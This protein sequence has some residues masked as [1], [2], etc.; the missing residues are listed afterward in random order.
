MV[1]TK[2]RGGEDGHLMITGVKADAMT[3]QDNI[4]LS[5]YGDF[6]PAKQLVNFRVRYLR[7]DYGG[8]TLEDVM[9]SEYHP[10][11]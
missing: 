1:V 8:T 7:T 5:L 11:K 3:L 2:M 9:L 4:T 6:N 10:I